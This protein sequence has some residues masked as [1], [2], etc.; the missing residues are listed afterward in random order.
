MVLLVGVIAVATS[1][2]SHI[3][4]RLD[5]IA[6]MKAL[7]ATSGRV[8]AVYFFQTAYLV[9]A[10]CIAGAILGI[11]LERAIVT[12]TPKL[13]SIELGRALELADASAS[14]NCG[15]FRRRLRSRSRPAAHPRR[16]PVPHVAPRH[17]GGPAEEPTPPRHGILVG[18]H[19][20]NR[21]RH[22]AC[23][24]RDRVVDGG[25][26]SACGLARRRLRIVGGS[27][28]CPGWLPHRGR[29][30]VVASRASRNRQH[31]PAGQR[32]AFRTRRHGR[33]GRALLQR[34]IW[35]KRAAIADVTE[36]FPAISANLFLLNIE[37]RRR[38]GR[39]KP[40]GV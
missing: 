33:R 15:L 22:A 13:F 21:R 34:S 39:R 40:V 37:A 6:V 11:A 17:G 7:G 4:Q 29:T 38:E 26:T 10:G 9:L 23:G 24:L 2:W 25:I 27:S 3:E 16:A 35:C 19:A 31:P 5:S 14:G 30:P 12:L 32:S 8:L 20:R 36:N 1:M 28:A 18:D